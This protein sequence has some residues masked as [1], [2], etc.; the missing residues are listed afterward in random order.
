MGR[1]V[2]ASLR[3]HKL[4]L[5]ATSLAIVVGVAFVSGTLI[6]SDT[7]RLAFDNLFSETTA[8]IDVV[9]TGHE[10]SADPFS[11]QRD[12]VPAELVEVVE[13]V[14][15][16][17]TVAPEVQG[18]AQLIS[19]DGEPVGGGGPPTLAMGAPVSEAI[20][21]PDVRSGRFPDSADE[22]AVDV[23]AFEALGVELGDTVGVVLSGPVQ[24]KTVV[25]TVGF[26][27]LDN[28][29]GATMVV[30][31]AEYAVQTFGQDGFTQLSVIA[32]DGVDAA[33]LRDRIA[34]VT[35]EVEVLTQL[36]AADQAAAQVSEGLGFFT[37]ALLVFA[38]VSL[39]VGAFLIA[40]TFT[41][42]MAQR[43]REMALLRAVGASRAQILRSVLAE[44][45][46]IGLIGSVLG[47]AAG[48]GLAQGLYALL[49]AFGIALPSGDP[50][51]AGRT[52][53]VAMGLGTVLTVVMAVVP[54]I[55]S[56]RVP[57]VAALQA[58][59]APSLK[60]TGPGRVVSG[61]VVFVGGVAGL[62]VSLLQSLGLAAVGAAA[63]VTLIGAA[64]LA[65]LV[66][67]PL[68]RLI[69][70]PVRASRGVQ[71][72]LASQ[73]AMR[74][75]QRTASTAS[76][77]MIGLALV[78]FVAI[79]AASFSASIEQTIEDSFG[80]DF[81]VS[82]T[83]FELG[84]DPGPSLAEDLAAVDGVALVVP[85]SFAFLEVE[86]EEATAFATDAGLY[87]QVIATEIIDGGADGLVGGGAAID[88]ESAA[89]QGLA[90]GDVVQMSALGGD[91]VDVEVVT[92][93]SAE[94]L[95]DGWLVDQAALLAAGISA[96]SFRLS[97]TYI[98]LADDADAA[99]VSDRLDDLLAAE[100]PALSVLDQTGL[101]EQITD[102]INQLLGL[103]TALLALS[104]LV[105][106]FGIV[107]TLGLSVL[108][109]TRELG[110]L[111]AVGATRPQ[112]RSMVRWESVLVALLGAVFGLTIGIL[113]AWLVV[114][115]L[116]EQQPLTLSIPPLQLLVGLVAAAVAGVVAAILP[117][118]RAARTD[119]LRALEA[120]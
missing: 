94:A 59:A 35:D 75:P 22:I 112:I 12:P 81:I 58:V 87:E 119:I 36:E 95:D 25:G 48:I 84:I 107:N 3:A 65:P 16:V 96:D 120:Q 8:G 40:N 78:S 76:A 104:V 97:S 77:L 1:A 10:D 103:I 100:Y 60:Q 26:G 6:L 117:A 4:R 109:R 62:A 47:F 118:R 70:G 80:C 34:A 64:F 79:L 21:T 91:P 71:G 56:T 57:P 32:D 27:D 116:A 24:D 83:G 28:L 101:M 7:L 46:V 38:G 13:A 41:I 39:F 19:G 72:E 114:T 50:V 37:T 33:D 73:N 115:A 98:E 88:E 9:V 29:A 45:L 15:G 85:E 68:V 111:R 102:Q 108:E 17:H 14:E 86:G 93:Y 66:T 106:L 52:F 63:V 110:L 5:L 18:L 67:R 55:R 43:T 69:G 105:A 74:N 92:I 20:T 82:Q 113:F 42:I 53:A 31:E 44:A 2:L 23:G 89:E 11:G 30:L 51:V 99:A 61:G 49:D 54:A 90:V